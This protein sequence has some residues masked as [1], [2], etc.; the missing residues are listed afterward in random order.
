MNTLRNRI[1]GFFILA[2][3]AVVALATLAA[4]TALRKPV[5]GRMMEPIAAQIEVLARI[6][7]RNRDE[8]LAAGLDIRKQPAEGTIEPGLS[9]FL[10]KALAGSGEARDARVTKTEDPQGTTASVRLE[11]SSWLVTPLP[12]PGP[13]PRGWQVFLTWIV[14]IAIGS[15]V[16]S[17]YAATRMTRPLRLI[18]SAA[19]TIGPDGTLSPLPEEGPAELKATAEALNRLSTRLRAAMESR[20]RLVAAAGHDLRTPMTRMRLRAEFIEDEEE[21]AKW[22]SDLEE[23]DMIAD[24]AIRLVREESA[25]ESAEPI[26]LDRLVRETVEELCDL[27]HSITAT[28][29]A[30]S[31]IA[32]QPMA[33]KRALCNLLINAATHGGGA[34]VAVRREGADSLVVITDEGPGIPQAQI[35]QVFEPFFRVDPAR[36]KS[37]P[38]A[39]LGLAIA[40]EIVERF[41]GRIEIANRSTGGLIQIARFKSLPENTL[42]SA[43]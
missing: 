29:L 42:D 11:D 6:A 38:G 32:A 26:A 4:S 3:V 34:E 8:A 43:S 36:R 12:D 33:L 19:A 28:T 22:L 5:P 23:L 37:V 31:V 18:E 1:A 35:G 17:I 21:R 41:G 39:G 13:P 7:S 25:E 16:V 40:R 20:M 10:A 15:A 2:I 27:G 14:L 24:S 30:P 9:G